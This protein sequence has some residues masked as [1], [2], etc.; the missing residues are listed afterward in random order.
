MVLINKVDMVCL[1]PVGY[2]V[3]LTFRALAL[4]RSRHHILQATNISYQHLKMSLALTLPEFTYQIVVTFC[5]SLT[6]SN[7]GRFPLLRSAKN[8]KSKKLSLY[9]LS[10]INKHICTISLKRIKTEEFVSNANE[11]SKRA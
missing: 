10:Q 8:E 6:R 7:S 11:L 3:K 5:F 9:F 1:S 4:R 2:G